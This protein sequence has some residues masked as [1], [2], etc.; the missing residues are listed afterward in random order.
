MEKAFII[1]M[2]A[3]KWK[4]MTHINMKRTKRKLTLFLIQ[5]QK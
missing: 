1:S 5:K 2:H 4:T 3:Q